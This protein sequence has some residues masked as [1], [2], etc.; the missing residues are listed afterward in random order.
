MDQIQTLLERYPAL[1]SQE[2]AIRR[3]G[4]L[5]CGAAREGKQVLTCGNGGSAAD[6]EHVVGELMKDF[7]RKRPIPEEMR[8]RLETVGAGDLAEGLQ[9]A[10]R[11]ICLNSQTSL[12]TALINDGDP[13]LAFA[14]QVY[15]YGREGDVLLGFSTSG[16]SRN[17]YHAVQVARAL[18][19]HIIVISGAS[20]GAIAPLADAAICVPETDT[21]KVQ[22]LTLPIYH[23]LCLQAE[24]ALFQ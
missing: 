18:G 15:G 16:N 2:T 7:H 11:A 17:V 13:D 20:G 23:A 1:C 6:A 4:E 22:E 24:D 21:Y 14:Q 12:L 5:L 10:V 8:R 3:A 19:M 9:Q